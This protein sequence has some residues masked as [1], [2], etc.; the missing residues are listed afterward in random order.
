MLRMILAMG[1]TRWRPRSSTTK[2]PLLAFNWGGALCKRV[3][4]SYS[5]SSVSRANSPP[6]VTTGRSHSTQ[7]PSA[8]R[9]CANV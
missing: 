2:M 5:R 4:G 8:F 6:T 3:W 9:S 7:R 1:L